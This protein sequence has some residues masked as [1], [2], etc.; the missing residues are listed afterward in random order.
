MAVIAPEISS[1]QPIP[2]MPSTL[3]GRNGSVGEVGA[4]ARASSSA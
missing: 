1:T 2:L 4:S 3:L